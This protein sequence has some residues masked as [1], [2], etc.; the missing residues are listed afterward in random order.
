MSS[1]FKLA[2][3]LKMTAVLLCTTVGFGCGLMPGKSSQQ[4]ILTYSLS[5]GLGQGAYTR[6]MPDAD[7]CANAQV[8]LPRS[9]PGFSTARMAYVRTAEQIE[10]FAFHQWVDTPAYML[11]PLLVSALVESGRFAHVV[12]APATVGS[13]FRLESD[14]VALV[15]QFSGG[16]NTVRLALRIRLVDVMTG[17]YLLDES[18]ALEKVAEQAGPV[19]GVAAA[20]AIAAQLVRKVAQDIG[21][22]IDVAAV[23]RQ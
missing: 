4:P 5:A 9:S 20:N 12:L 16:T 17:T 19:S 13:R 10:Y 8:L 23:C 11:Q 1:N 6:A 14:D 21:A 15:Q 7:S 2:A 3:A 18:V 22:A